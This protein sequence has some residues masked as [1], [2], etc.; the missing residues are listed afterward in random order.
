M[1]LKLFL[2]LL[3]SVMAMG[4]LKAQIKLDTPVYDTVPVLRL[5]SDTTVNRA[6][7]SV[8]VMRLYEVRQVSPYIH[9]RYLDLHYSRL[10]ERLKVWEDVH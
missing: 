8:W 9:I 6:S 2:P 5:V 10:N 3:L 4:T 7:Y 1:K